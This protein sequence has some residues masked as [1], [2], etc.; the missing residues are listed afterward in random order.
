MNIT[1]VSK[2]CI[3]KKVDNADNSGYV[4]DICI[5]NIHSFSVPAEIYYKLNLYDKSEISAEELDI[6]K[7]ESN[8]TMAKTKALVYLSFKM[9][10]AKEVEDKLLRD[11]FSVQTTRRTVRELIADGY[12]NDEL[13]VKKYICDRIKLKPKSKNMLMYELKNKGIEETVIADGLRELEVDNISIAMDLLLRKFKNPNL[14]D[15]K[16]KRKAFSFLRYRGFSHSEIISAINQIV[17]GTDDE[18]P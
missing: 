3:D 5:D 2:R 16:I 6:I 9:R 17:N 12:I 8:F 1:S 4:Y 13:Y 18:M 11:G 10:T 14:T 7:K 15:V